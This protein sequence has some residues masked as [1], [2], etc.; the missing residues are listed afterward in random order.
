MKLYRTGKGVFV[1]DAGKY[2]A[3]DT[4]DWDALISQPGLLARV[5][6]C[7]AGAAVNL[8]RRVFWRRWWGRRF[9]RRG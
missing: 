4:N 3:V 6:A 2:F 5:K 8:M 7:C 1:E 9:G